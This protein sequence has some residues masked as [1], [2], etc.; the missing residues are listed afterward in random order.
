M[1]ICCYIFFWKKSIFDH[2]TI[3]RVCYWPLNS[4][5]G[6]LRPS[7]YQN[8]SLL[9]IR[10]FCRAV[11]LTWTPRGGG[12]HL[13]AILSPLSLS[14]LPPLSS[15]PVPLLGGPLLPAATAAAPCSSSA[16]AP[17]ACAACCCRR[18]L[19]QQ[20]PPPR[21]TAG[22]TCCSRS[23]RPLRAHP[24]A[25]TALERK[26]GAALGAAGAGEEGGSG[27]GGRRGRGRRRERR[28]RPPG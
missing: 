22:A 5:T 27:G 2:P 12:A 28:W 10:R 13:S 4:K 16:A 1:N 18:P 20:A 19:L 25:A 6:Y 21:T 9:A 15:F 26:E 23:R 7:N 3:A 17:A 8:R 11:S 14:F 24:A